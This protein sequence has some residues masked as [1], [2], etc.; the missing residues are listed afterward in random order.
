VAKGNN[1]NILQH[2]VE[3]ECAVVLGAE[4]PRLVIGF[5]HAMAPYEDC[6]NPKRPN[7]APYAV[8]ARW[9]E[10]ARYKNRDISAKPA[11][12]RAY[13]ATQASWS[14]YPNSA[15]IVRAVLGNTRMAG[16]VCETEPNKAEAL[17]DVW[18]GTGVYVCE[19]SWRNLADQFGTMQSPWLLS[20]DPSTYVA[21]RSGVN[22]FSID[23][24]DLGS[25]AASMSPLLKSNDSPGAVTIFCY[26]LRPDDRKR[27]TGDAH[28]AFAKAGWRT[29]PVFLEASGRG[30][31]RHVGAIL[32]NVP[33]VS[34]AATRAWA[35]LTEQ[36]P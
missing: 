25:V 17:R 20:L 21:G 19:S 22:D 10:E 1:G 4:A 18:R 6:E 3:A 35:V 2:C 33:E 14:H 9:L 30:G 36:S 27:F 34:E 32:T 23:V 28:E 5:T 24:G 7:P 26:E 16:F 29:P 15:E 12:V 31:N 11:V 8:L 13:R